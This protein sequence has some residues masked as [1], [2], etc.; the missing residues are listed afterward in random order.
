[1]RLSVLAVTVALLSACLDSLGA[2]DPTTPGK[3]AA[4]WSENQKPASAEWDYGPN[5]AADSDTM[6]GGFGLPISLASGDTL[7]VFALAKR[8][9]LSTA[10]YRLGWYGGT[11]GRLIARHS[12]LLPR[13]QSPCTPPLTGPIICNWEESD[14]FVVGTGWFPGV[15]LLQFKDAVGSTRSF[16]FVVRS[17]AHAAFTVILPFATYQAY[18]RWG[19]ASLYGGPGATRQEAYAN[20]LVKVA[21]ARPLSEVIVQNHFLGVDYPLVRWLEQNA[22]DVNYITDYDFHLGVGIDQQARGW[23]FAGHSEYWTWPMWLRA[24]AARDQG[25]NLGF[26]GGNDIYWLTRFETVSV[27]GLEAPVVVCY[28]DA[29]R[30]PLCA[31]P[32]MATVLFRSPPNNTPENALVGVMSSPPTLVK[33]SPIDLVVDDASDSLMDGTGL[34]A[35]EHISRVAGWEADRTVNN[36]F[37]PS[38]I[39]VLFQSPFVSA[40]DSVT[41][42]LMESTVYR[43]TPSGALV[44]AG[45]EPGFAW[46]LETF[47]NRTARPSLQRL[48][49][50]LLQAFVVARNQR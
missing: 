50:N 32:G 31:T 30:D 49:Q 2:P 14:R 33:G 39:H 11:G 29:R 38:G 34:T 18:N 43:W 24:N 16:P 17:T 36:G 23:L 41:P 13:E 1:M 12:G 5:G 15:Y 21:F 42:G 7:H 4:L 46:G 27:D 45:G 22:Y 3:S 25:I 28:R 48:L 20:R 10:V 40:S 35:G 44:F 19:G 37:A 6:L 47:R 8:P 26:I 9:P